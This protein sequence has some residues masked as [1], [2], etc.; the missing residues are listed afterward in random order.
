MAT[1]FSFRLY[2]LGLLV[3]VGV[4]TLV[5]RLYEVQVKDYEFYYSQLPGEKEVTVRVPGVRGE[6]KDRNGVVL[7]TNKATYEIIF[8]LKEIYENYRQEAE[9]VPTIS[10]EAAQGGMRRTREEADIVEIV[11]ETVIPDLEPFGLVEDF[12][13]TQMQVHFRSTR[14]VVPYSYRRDLTF[15]DLAR[16][17]ENDF[18]VPG[19]KVEVKPLRVYPFDAMASHVMGYVKQPDIQTVPIERRKEFDHYVPDEYGGA[20][21][22]K[23]MDAY[24][25]GKAGKRVLRRDEKGVIR[26]EIA[27]ERPKAG[28]DVHLTIDAKVQYVAEQAM[29]VIGRG[30]AVVMDPRNGDVLAMVSVPSFDPNRFV[31]AVSPDDWKRYTTDKAAPLFN[32]AL[33]QHPPGSTFKIP[34]SLAGCLSDSHRRRFYCAGGVQYGA[35]Y[36]KCWIAGRGGRHGSIG[37]SD[38]IK[39]SCNCYFYQFGNHTGIENIVEVTSYLGLGRPTGIPLDGEAPGLVPSPQWL[40]LQGLLWSDAFTAMTSIGQ[41]Y[42]EATPL[43]MCSVTCSVANGGKVYK[44]RLVR[45]IV[46]HDGTV[47]VP[48]KPVLKYDL[49]E[50]GLTSDEVE[51]VKRGMWQV[52]NEAGGTAG[53]ARA[54]NFEVSGKTGT[55][56]T[57]IPSEPTSAWFIAFAPYDEPEYAVSVFVHNGD[58]GGKAAAPIAG[59]ILKQCMAMK[60]GYDPAPRALA[61]AKGHFDKI[62]LVSFDNSGLDR[63]VEGDDADMAVEL[64]D[65]FRYSVAT[66]SSRTSTHNPSIR[67]RADS[68]GSVSSSSRYRSSDYRKPRQPVRR[69]PARK[70]EGLFKKLFGGG[71]R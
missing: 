36:M 59:H 25:Q 8:D 68:R 32:R 65:G 21:V 6:I 3:L 51:L 22:E 56:Q 29:R 30:A 52:V 45:K 31:P 4:G 71:R 63:Y 26:G 69:A 49:T 24:L 57:G 19:V 17:A 7:A 60:H 47:V 28:A 67:A 55:A 43:Q 5:M 15:D 14:G 18:D 12:N 10:Y 2:L 41:G 37:I 58:S 16:F 39:K 20:G 27:Y 9:E 44:P 11:K 40:K 42:A 50:Q 61:E 38:A 13:A 33:S 35:K 34:V 23:T 53:R 66:S 48:D 54:E 70:K 46:D 64:P 62:N 1:K